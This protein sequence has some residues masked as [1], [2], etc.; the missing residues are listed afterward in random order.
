M[1]TGM[2]LLSAAENTRAAARLANLPHPVRLHFFTQA[3]DCESCD[4]TRRLLADL[5]ALAPRLIVDEHNLVLDRDPPRASPSTA[6]RPSPW[7]ATPTPA[8]A[9]SAPRWVTS[10]RRCST[11]SS[12]CRR[13]TRGSRPRAARSSPACRRRSRFRC[14]RRPPASI[15]RRP[16]ALAHRAALESP[17]VSATGVSVIE[18]PDLIRRYR[19]T[20]VPKIVLNDR[21]ELLGRPARGR[22]HR[23]HPR[24]EPRAFER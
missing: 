10:S 12:R 22:L 14:S 19:V 1:L 6:P 18:F 9:S 2:P 5:A 21:V 4:D 11:P 24:G 23:R 3:L 7:S 15:A 13:A 20:G 8:S 16:S 17:Q